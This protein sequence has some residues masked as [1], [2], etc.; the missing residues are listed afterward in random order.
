LTFVKINGILFGLYQE[1]DVKGNKKKDTAP[2]KIKKPGS[3][4]KALGAKAGK[5]LSKS[6]LQAA[7]KKKGITGQRA[8]YALNVLIPASKKRAAKAKAKKK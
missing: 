7:A 4:R 3:L 1:G 5:P 8:R 2:I 6:K